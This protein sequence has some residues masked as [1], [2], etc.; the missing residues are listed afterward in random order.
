M[1]PCMGRNKYM[2]AKSWK[3]EVGVTATKRHEN[4]SAWNLP[5]VDARGY[6]QYLHTKTHSYIYDEE[7]CIQTPAESAGKSFYSCISSH[8]HKHIDED[9]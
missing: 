3:L 7:K 1:C 8:H 2:V 5:K 9:T 6:K 4:W